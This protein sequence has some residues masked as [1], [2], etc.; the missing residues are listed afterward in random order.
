MI[1]ISGRDAGVQCRCGHIRAVHEHYSV[2]TNKRCAVC[3]CEKFRRRG[4]LR[5]LG[6]G[7]ARRWPA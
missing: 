4:I 6:D 1:I 5:R 3:R 2:P 7:I